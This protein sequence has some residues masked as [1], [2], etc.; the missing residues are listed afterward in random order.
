MKST[1]RL[2]F[3]FKYL[4]LSWILVGHFSK[5][6][7]QKIHSIDHSIKRGVAFLN[8]SKDQENLIMILPL[9]ELLNKNFNIGITHKKTNM[10]SLLMEKYAYFLI[11]L[12]RV[13]DTTAHV[14][15]DLLEPYQDDL[16][17]YFMFKSF[18]CDVFLPDTFLVQKLKEGLLIG[19][20]DLTHALISMHWLKQFDCLEEN[21]I[22]EKEIKEL[23][24]T[25]WNK[26]PVM[27]K[28][29][30]NPD[31]RYESIAIAL[32]TNKK[33]NLSDEVQSILREQEKGGSW[34]NQG[35]SDASR[36]HTTILALW[37]LLEWRYPEAIAKWR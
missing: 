20:Y 30:K 35:L 23:Q 11:G 19:G 34:Y 4:F 6:Y 18:N 2:F 24:E 5:T 15:P 7:S 8:S 27:A 21:A 13:F 10:D 16:I 17:N 29:E 31:L 3:K 12:N 9:I 25:F 26:L 14:P 37:A 33:I 1:M 32:H 36:E 28:T 22:L